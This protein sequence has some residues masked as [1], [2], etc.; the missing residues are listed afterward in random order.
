MDGTFTSTIHGDKMDN[1]RI[2]IIL[3]CIIIALLAVMVVMFSPFVAKEDSKLAIEN[4]TINEGDSL[5]VLLSDNKGVPISGNA[6]NIKLTDDDGNVISENCTTDSDGQAK[7]KVDKKGKYCVEC[8]FNGN[9]QYS[10]GSLSV[11]LTVENAK[12]ELVNEEQT[13]TTSHT[14]KYAPNGGIYPEYGPE[15]DS[16]GVT[17]EYAIANDWHYMELIIDG[18]DVGGYVAYDPVN[19]CYHT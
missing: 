3:L 13:S 14:S 17:R 5:V 1:Q 19:G 11:N 8:K 16:H 15:V 2:I 10:A 6:V 12:T 4:T 9:D 7:L 18:K